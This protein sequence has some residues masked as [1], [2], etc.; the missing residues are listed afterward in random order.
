VWKERTTLKLRRF[1][2]G[3]PTLQLFCLWKWLQQT[4][5][6]WTPIQCSCICSCITTPWIRNSDWM[7]WNS[8]WTNVNWSP[9]IAEPIYIYYLY[10][11]ILDGWLYISADVR[12]WG[13]MLLPNLA[14]GGELSNY[15][16][17]LLPLL[18]PF[19]SPPSHSLSPCLS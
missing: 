6:N 10:I 13:S 7:R 1:E 15:W 9:C 14:I 3:I 4:F 8:C 16:S 19:S 5:K 17:F 2:A 11:F 12:A 18:H